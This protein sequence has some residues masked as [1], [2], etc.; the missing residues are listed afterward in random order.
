MK[1]RNK[2]GLFIAFEGIDGCGKGTQIKKLLE[3]IN[4]I[5]KYNPLLLTREPYS[6]TDI[7]TILK[8][9]DNP[10]SQK[11]KLTELFIY[12]RRKHL[13][14]L[15]KP[16]LKKG[17]HV[18]SDRYSLSTLA[19][20]NAQG[21]PLNELLRM[22]KGILIPDIIFLIDISG[23]EAVERMQ[24]DF[25]RVEE[26]KFEKSAE[27]LE[28]LRKNYLKLSDLKNHNIV[29]INGMNKPEQIFNEQ[30]LPAFHKIY[31][32]YNNSR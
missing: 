3:Y 5:S 10:Y 32:S 14:N 8:S 27:F 28:K 4:N 11:E 16:N 25:S 17:V 7:R 21:M 23:Q 31:N 18:I 20:Q 22:H 30:I 19:Y 24:K 9:E 29:L 1:K 2:K 26:Q 12:D 13:K 6:D 15:I